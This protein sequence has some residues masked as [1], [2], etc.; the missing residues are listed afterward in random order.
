MWFLLRNG[1]ARPNSVWC[2]HF[3]S[4]PRPLLPPSQA[5]CFIARPVSLTSH[6]IFHAIFVAL[7]P[8]NEGGRP[9]QCSHQLASNSRTG[10][11][12]R[13]YKQ[14][15]SRPSC[16]ESMSASKPVVP[17]ASDKG[18]RNWPHI[19][20]GVTRQSVRPPLPLTLQTNRTT[21]VVWWFFSFPEYSPSVVFV[22][23]P[24]TLSSPFLR[25]GFCHRQHP[26]MYL[27]SCLLA[28]FNGIHVH[29]APQRRRIPIA[30]TSRSM[31]V[32]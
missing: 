7:A 1:D 14:G 8:A 16:C 23:P 11:H 28:L 4:T 9:S 20:E 17:S 18:A 19:V 21:C 6:L 22:N 31:T 27:L 2:G 15:C 29:T 32:W 12:L 25:T 26:S 10:T 5:V 13:R 3:R 24:P 30:D